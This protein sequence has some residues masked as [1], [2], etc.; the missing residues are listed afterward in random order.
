MPNLTPNF[1]FNLPLVNNSTDSD[2]WGGYLNSN[3]TSID[4]LLL[5][6]LPS[7]VIL[8]YA[9]TTPPTG[10]LLCYGQAVSRATYSGLFSLFGTQYGIGDGS[11]TFN[12][13][14]LRGR[15][16]AGLDNIGG[17]A[18]NRVTEGGSGIAGTVIGG[19][20]GGELLQSHTHT[21]ND[22]GHAHAFG[23]SVPIAIAGSALLTS[24]SPTSQSITATQTATTGITI[25]SSGGGG[26]QNM[27]PTIMMNKI[28]IT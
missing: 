15:V 23:G 8:D 9:W 20:G 4:T 25:A 2:L 5:G 27:Q 24:G 14:D 26:G 3:F 19:S 28:I 13:P 16:S 11:T 6:L 22:P 10:W 12:I 1:D 18:A 7:G 21:V 17:S